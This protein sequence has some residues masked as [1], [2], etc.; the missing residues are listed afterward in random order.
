MLR[1]RVAAAEGR[2]AGK[3]AQADAVAQGVDLDR[4]GDELAAHHRGQPVQQRV[5][6][7][8]AGGLGAEHRPAVD[9]R[10]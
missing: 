1:A 3:A 10:G 9:A 5:G 6:E 8:L 7:Q 2:Q 4:V